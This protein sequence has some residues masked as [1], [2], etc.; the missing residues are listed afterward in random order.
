MD[1]HQVR[2][3]APVMSA[4]FFRMT[5]TRDPLLTG[6]AFPYDVSGFSRLAT[7]DFF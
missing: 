3:G 1:E 6:P 4:L 5:E 7:Y 2:S